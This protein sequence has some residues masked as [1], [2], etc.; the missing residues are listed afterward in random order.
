MKTIY[1]NEK[2]FFAKVFHAK[3]QF[4]FFFFDASSS[5]VAKSANIR[6]GHVIKES[7]DIGPKKL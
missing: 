2:T 4:F 5:L 7:R 3:K 6:L 1:A